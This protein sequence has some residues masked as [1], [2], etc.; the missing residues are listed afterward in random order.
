MANGEWSWRSNPMPLGVVSS[1][2]RNMC[3][4]HSLEPFVVSCLWNFRIGDLP[5]TMAI[6]PNG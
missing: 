6:T 5:G 4:L 3:S 1:L 2:P